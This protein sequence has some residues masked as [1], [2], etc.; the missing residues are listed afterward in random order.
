MQAL[1]R[2]YR[3]ELQGSQEAKTAETVAFIWVFDSFRWCFSCFP[4]VCQE[5]QKPTCGDLCLEDF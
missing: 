1:R 4:E 5:V 3:K 2:V